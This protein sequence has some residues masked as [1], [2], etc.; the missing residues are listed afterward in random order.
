[1]VKAAESAEPIERWTENRRVVLVVSFIKDE[2]SVA[3]TTRQYGMIVAEVEDWWEK[4]LLQTCRVSRNSE[5]VLC[6]T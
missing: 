4:F 3:E 1:M 5:V 2:I 6:C